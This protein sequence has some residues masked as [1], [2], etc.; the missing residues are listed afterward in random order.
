MENLKKMMMLLAC[1]FFLAAFSS[2]L[3]DDDNDDNNNVLTSSQKS[4]QIYEMAG[5]YNGHLFTTNDSTM[6][7]DSISCNWRITANDSAVIIPNFPVA[8]LANG[9]SN[10]DVKKCL[11]EGG[12]TT[13]KATL[14]PF[15]NSDHTK[16][17]YTFWMLVNDD[18]MAFTIEDNGNS[19]N[20]KVE[21]AYQMYINY[22]LGNAFFY[23]TG[24]Y[25]TNEILSYILVNKVDFD[26]KTFT[27]AW[28]SYIYGK[29]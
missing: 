27:T 6:K 29:K 14:H 17:L 3:G 13:L 2:C 25:M 24:K 28:P 4:A 23:S 19:H 8:V 15:Y 10:M 18:N 1:L 26:D 21:F 16:G 9:I 7:L 11:L 22:S 12:T 5:T 20:V